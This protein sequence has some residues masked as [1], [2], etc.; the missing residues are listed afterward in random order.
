MTWLGHFGEVLLQVV[1][2][3]LVFFGALALSLVLTPCVRELNR[4]MG[5]VDAPGARRI[6][7]V[8]IPRGGGVAVILAFAVSTAL[9]TLIS[10]RTLSPSI[11]NAVYWRMLLLSISIGAIGYIDDR[12]GMKPLLKLAGQI[13]VASLAFFW[14]DTS[15]HKSFPYLPVCFDYCFTVFWIVGA[16]NAFNLID[17]LDG[18]ASGLAVI[19]AMGMAGALFFIG[20]PAQI[21]L[22]LAFIGAV[23]GFLRYNFNPASV[24]LGDS[25]SMFIGFMLSTIPLHTQSADSLLVGLGVPLLAMGVPIFDT[26]L[27]IL[28]RTIRAILKR[29]TSSGEVGNTKVMQPDTDH[30]HHRMLRKFVSQRKTAVVMYVF[31]ALMTITGLLAVLARDRAAGLFIVAF[32]VASIVVVRDMTGVELVDAGHLADVVAH[33]SSKNRRR[34][35]AAFSVPLLVAADI[36]ILCCSWLFAVLVLGI[37]P[38][39]RSFHTFMP[40]YV[41]LVFIAIVF[42]RGYSTVWGRAM[43]SNFLR[44]VL[45]VACG[46]LLAAAAIILLGYGSSVTFVFP[47]VYAAF[48][49]I[50]LVAVRLLRPVFRDAFYLVNVKKM[51]ETP[52]AS[53]TLVFGAGLRYRTFRRELVRKINSEKRIIVGVIDDDILMRGKYIGGVLVDGPH[54]DIARIKAATRADSVVIACELP[55]KQLKAVAELF[56][57]Q[58]L[59]VTYFTFT[60]TEV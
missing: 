58:G 14:A 17:G 19:A 7:K 59:K 43:I 4:R 15:F 29:R 31:A 5:M 20:S 1:P 22:Y 41:S 35:R 42:S 25:G 51:L 8:P 44:L 26:S 53:R 2:Y 11:S 3:L 39:P 9:F 30:L 28:R 6:N 49:F 23:L 57:K 21:L 50:P 60:E 27:A 16:I 24:F 48:A 34:R 56:R 54:A 33:D 13:A 32:I 46:A 36:A 12:F 55:P 37:K 52:D 45:A 10:G 47:F 38:S 18:L 40:I